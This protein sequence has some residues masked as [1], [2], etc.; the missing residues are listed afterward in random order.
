[1]P[2]I[3]ED[4]T[5]RLE[6]LCFFNLIVL[7]TISAAIGIARALFILDGSCNFILAGLIAS[8]YGTLYEALK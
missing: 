5:F 7:F 3:F 1:M 8:N 6:L 4:W 2:E